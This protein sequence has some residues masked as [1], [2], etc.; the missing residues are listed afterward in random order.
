VSARQENYLEEWLIQ[1]GS[2]GLDV[3]KMA[4]IGDQYLIMG[5][6]A[7]TQSKASGPHQSDFNNEVKVARKLKTNGRT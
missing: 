6:K 1:T 7:S 2:I 5:S 4:V 3:K